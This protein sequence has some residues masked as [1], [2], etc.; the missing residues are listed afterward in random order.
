[1]QH[2][3]TPVLLLTQ[4]DFLWQHWRA[5]DKQWLP[6][7]G[8]ELADLRRWREQGHL[9]AI[10]DIGLPGLPDWQ[11]QT[12]RPLLAGM[13]VVVASVRPTDAEGMQAMM[14]GAVG[15]CHAYAPATT[16]DRVLQAVASGSVWMGASLMSRLLRQVDALAA[17]SIA[18]KHDRATPHWQ[19][20]ALSVREQII[21]HRVAQ[22]ESNSAI[23][24]AMGISERTVKAH[25]TS[26]FDKLGIHD[27][28]Q[29][30]LLV[31]GVL[32]VTA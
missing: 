20:D 15:Y 8:R 21:A 9:I 1:V 10:L 23:A 5:L 2:A 18:S 16:L 29:L 17:A 19:H 3:T 22:G 11:A 13:Q 7:R 28:L 30:A 12:W 6:A 32:D 26:I 31:H 25:L 14:V 4:D 27:R 24:T